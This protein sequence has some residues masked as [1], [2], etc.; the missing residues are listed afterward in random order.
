MISVFFRHFKCARRRR[1][2][3]RHWSARGVVASLVGERL[4]V[5]V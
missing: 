3:V 4:M 5:H 2:F 1:Y